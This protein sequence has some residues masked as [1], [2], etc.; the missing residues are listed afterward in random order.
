MGQFV[1]H[2]R[3]IVVHTEASF[4]PYRFVRLRH[5]LNNVKLINNE[6]RLGSAACFISRKQLKSDIIAFIHSKI[7]EDESIYKH[8]EISSAS[9]IGRINSNGRW[10]L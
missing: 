5:L 7:N 2:A 3:G 6:A 8:L 4:Y 10:L 9:Y 1:S